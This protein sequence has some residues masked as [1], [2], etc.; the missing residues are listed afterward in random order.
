MA[1]TAR[2]RV[3]RPE[4]ET[5]RAAA[6][7]TVAAMRQAGLLEPVDSTRVRMLLGL[8]EAVDADPTNA[9]LWRELRAAEKALRE[10]EHGDSDAFGDLLAAM[11]AEV[12]DPSH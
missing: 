6:E 1:G 3:K 2:K 9:A 11:S 8:A 7:H 12:R 5:N 10:S 4:P